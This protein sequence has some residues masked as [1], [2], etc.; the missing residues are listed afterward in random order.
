MKR[1]IR[2]AHLMVAICIAHAPATVLAR[3][4]VDPGECIVTVI[5]A[6]S[7]VRAEIDKWVGAEQACKTTLEVRVLAT[8]GGYYLWARDSFGREHERIV[9]DA[10][11]AG[12]LVAS[13]V[14]DDSYVV[15]IPIDP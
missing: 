2:H 7:E 13:W 10:Q 6:P 14:A 11:T 5:R 15:A 4:T 8:D 12:V 3:P 1:P 9:P